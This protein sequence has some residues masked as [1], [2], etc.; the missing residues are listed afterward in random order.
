MSTYNGTQ[1]PWF[2]VGGRNVLGSRTAIECDVMS[3]VKVKTPLG[4]TAVV[5]DHTG[6]EQATITQ[7]GYFDE[8]A[9]GANEAVM[10]ATGRSAQVVC[11]SFAD[12]SAGSDMIGC[13]GAL[14]GSYTRGVQV[15]EF[16]RA[17][18]AMESTGAVDDNCVVIAPL[19]TRAGAADTTAV[20]NA[21]SSASG[22]AAYLQVSALTL[23]GYT[24]MV[25]KLQ[26]SANNSTWA[27]LITFTAVTAAPAAERKTVTGTVNRYL[28]ASISYTGSGTGNSATV[29][30]GAERY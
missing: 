12:G 15:E 23:G 27:D 13:A 17:N 29:L 19:T 28:R 9:G 24:N 14:V 8:A 26:H 4:T 16:H 1:V 10:G 11:L 6:V 3:P 2:L 7:Q 20:D 5:K 22:C 25:V 30:V 21:A 18:A